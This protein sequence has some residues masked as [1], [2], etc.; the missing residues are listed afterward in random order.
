M[1][2]A[3]MAYDERIAFPAMVNGSFESGRILR[4]LEFN[5]YGTCEGLVSKALSDLFR[6]KDVDRFDSIIR[7]CLTVVFNRWSSVPV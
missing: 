4:V 3:A 2:E 6:F 5:E 7:Q 1:K